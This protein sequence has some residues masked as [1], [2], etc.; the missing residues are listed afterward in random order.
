MKKT[1]RVV[2]EREYEI[3]IKDE[4]LNQE[5]VNAFEEGF[6]ELD[7]DT[8]EDKI[9]DLFKSVAY[10]LNNGEEYFIEGVGPCANVH[11]VKYKDAHGANTTVV[12]NDTF[13]EIET[14]IVE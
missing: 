3:E 13:E 2:T 4:I 1:V 11:T 7:G 8:L 9:N 10:Q 14:E 12:W 5:F 6:W